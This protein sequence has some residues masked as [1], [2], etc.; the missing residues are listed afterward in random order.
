MNYVDL[1]KRLVDP[2]GELKLNSAQTAALIKVLEMA[3]NMQEQM[4]K[5]NGYMEAHERLVRKS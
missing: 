5:I 4:D 1:V 2:K 3:Q